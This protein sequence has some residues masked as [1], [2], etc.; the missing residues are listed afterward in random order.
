MCIHKTCNGIHNNLKIENEH[1]KSNNKEVQ[2][3]AFN[4]I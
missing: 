2:T 3:G 4:S 1:Y